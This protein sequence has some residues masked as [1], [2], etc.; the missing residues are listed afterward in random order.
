MDGGTVT[1]G[2]GRRVGGRPSAGVVS[3]GML[4]MACGASGRVLPADASTD[5][6]TEAA[7]TI[8]ASSY[9]QSCSK[10]QDCVQVVDGTDLCGASCPQCGVGAIN[11][12]SLAEYNADFA[13]LPIP[14]QDAPSCNCPAS[15]EP[16]CREDVCQASCNPFRRDAASE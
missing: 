9:N 10:D 14:A 13:K 3:F 15:V 4:L 12:A 1:N 11:R 5:A 2:A 8:H 16:C 6:A 7:C